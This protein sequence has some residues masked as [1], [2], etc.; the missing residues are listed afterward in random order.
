[1]ADLQRA[2]RAAHAWVGEVPG[3]VAV[4]QGEQG[5][6]PCVDVWVTAVADRTRIPAEQDGVPVVVRD[7]GGE[8][9]IQPGPA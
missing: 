2:L 4:G 7:S 8:V 6:R 1:M 3:V 5:G 9:S